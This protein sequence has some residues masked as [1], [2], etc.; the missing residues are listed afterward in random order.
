MKLFYS[1]FTFVVISTTSFGQDLT[2]TET[3]SAIKKL[4]F[5][6][7]TWRGSGWFQSGQGKD[8]LSINQIITIIDSGITFQMEMSSE[9]LS[10]NTLFNTTVLVSYD[11]K[12]KNFLTSATSSGRTSNG[13]ALI[14]DDHILQ[15]RYML[16]NGREFRYTYSVSNNL[17]TIAGEVTSDNGAS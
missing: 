17:E 11:A 2:K 8:S 14:I 1:L 5:L 16:N 7:G 3:V 6:V 12:N 9:I 15:C 10:T 4:S 13:P